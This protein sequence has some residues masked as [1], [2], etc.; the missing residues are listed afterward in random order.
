MIPILINNFLYITIEYI[1][2][3]F[4]KISNKSAYISNIHLILKN[5]YEFV[6]Q[7]WK[8]LLRFFKLENQRSLL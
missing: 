7:K 8:I 4:K 2:L 1:I 5:I 6:L 3:F